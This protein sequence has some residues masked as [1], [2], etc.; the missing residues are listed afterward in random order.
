MTLGPSISPMKI[1]LLH[2]LLRRFVAMTEN[3]SYYGVHEQTIDRCF[4]K[5]KEM[6]SCS[7]FGRDRHTREKCFHSPTSESYIKKFNFQFNSL[8]R[9]SNA[10]YDQS[11]NHENGPSFQD[12]RI[13]LFTHSVQKGEVPLPFSFKQNWFANSSCTSH[14]F[15]HRKLFEFLDTAVTRPVET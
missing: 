12:S 10:N 5:G 3:C 9:R 8:H 2:W 11:G 4:W 14:M 1:A 7:Q 13:G 6:Q 15:N